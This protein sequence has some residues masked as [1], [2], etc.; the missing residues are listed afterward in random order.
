MSLILKEINEKCLTLTLNRPEKRNALSADMYKELA[1]ELKKQ[2]QNPAIKS[3]LIK[4]AGEHFTAGND[5]AQFAKVESKAELQ[6]TLEFMQALMQFPM[7]VVAQVS[8]MAVGIGTTMLL[9][10]DLVYCDTSCVFSLPFINLALVPEYA[11]SLLLPQLAGHRKASEWLLL[12]ESFGAEQAREFG[13]VNDVLE[14][15]Q[16]A[17]HCQKVVSQLAVKPYAALRHTKALMKSASDSVNL[18]IDKEIEVFVE[19]LKSEAAKEAFS[20][21]LEKRKPDPKKYC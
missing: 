18:H 3:V 12:G 11:S 16:L 13:L 17:A 6:S 5:L 8:G 4:G 14:P 15:E 7:P 2:Q 20:A 9:H 19:Q 21:F 1:D 10:C